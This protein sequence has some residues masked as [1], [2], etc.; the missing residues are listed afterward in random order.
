M[1]SSAI[2]VVTS[3]IPHMMSLLHRLLCTKTRTLGARQE[4]K[5]SIEDCG[6]AVISRDD[7]LPSYLE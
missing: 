5:L 6:F 7:S 4:T 2:E 1:E 3:L